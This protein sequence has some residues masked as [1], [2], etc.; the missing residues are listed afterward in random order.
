MTK[1]NVVKLQEGR[2]LNGPAIFIKRFLNENG[3]RIFWQQYKIIADHF[4]MF[5][6]SVICSSL[7][8]G[9]LLFSVHY[10]QNLGQKCLRKKH[11]TLWSHQYLSPSP[12]GLAEFKRHIP[13]IFHIVLQ[14]FVLWAMLFPLLL[15]P[16][17]SRVFLEVFMQ[18]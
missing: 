6:L 7:P 18:R 10:W 11:T 17:I 12:V 13:F 4:S 1:L 9:F 3:Y 8:K 16:Q 5:F 14:A 15:S 2:V